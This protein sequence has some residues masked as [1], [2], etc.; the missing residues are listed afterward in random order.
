MVFPFIY[1]HPFTQSSHC[2]LSPTVFGFGPGGG[3]GGDERS[4]ALSSLSEAPVW[5][6]RKADKPFHC[7]GIKAEMETAF[8]NCK[9]PN[10]FLNSS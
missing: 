6:S 10:C 4:S 3:G 8:Q 1:A 2:F 7:T 9:T 5:W